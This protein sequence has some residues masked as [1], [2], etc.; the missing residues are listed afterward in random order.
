MKKYLF[1]LFAVILLILTH[2]GITDMKALTDKELVSVTGQAG[3]SGFD[4]VFEEPSQTGATTLSTSDDLIRK[5]VFEEVFVK[6]SGSDTQT[7]T[8]TAFGDAFANKLGL[9]FTRN[10]E[11]TLNMNIKMEQIS[12]AQAF[13]KETSSQIQ[14]NK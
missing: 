7:A 13:T 2:F 6:K 12:F 5:K 10:T 11:Q 8:I 1:P 14:F 4:T 3:I 9:D